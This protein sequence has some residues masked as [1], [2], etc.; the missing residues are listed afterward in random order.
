MFT[1][2]GD[3]ATAF[4]SRSQGAKLRAEMSRLG[5][6]LTTGLKTDI[7][8]AVSGD[9]GPIAGI[10]HDLQTLLAYK[11]ATDEAAILANTT[12]IALE[13]IQS[14]GEDLVSGM[15]TA[16]SSKNVTMVQTTAMD[17]KQKFNSAVSQLNTDV[18]GRSL[19]AGA[20]TDKAPLVSGE[21]MLEAIMVAI[22]SDTNA[23]DISASI[24][25]WF[26]DPAG[27][28]ATMAYLGSD[29]P[30]GPI[31]LGNGEVAD[32]TIR[33]N[34]QS[35]KDVLKATVKS[36]V[37][38]EGALNGSVEQQIE[39]TKIAAQDLLSANDGLVLAR[40]GIG[41]VEARVDAAQTRNEAEKSA[42][43]IT[44]SN[45]ISA[46]PYDTATELQ[47]AYSQLESLYTVTARMSKLN[48]TDFMR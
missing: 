9:F 26:D 2:F 30:M 32:L 11:T 3:L 33:A 34:D 18:M 25:A 12:Q 24:D 6:E 14:Q 35:I 16:T 36:A 41:A 31:R 10:E 27:G 7:S 38:A 48:F 15:L 37:M 47:A 43:E 23:A 5:V 20:A 29:N 39:L 8:R 1:T 44:R 45:L 28:F 13:T 40:A 22:A 19:F 42:L 17:A 4:H 46:D 21:E